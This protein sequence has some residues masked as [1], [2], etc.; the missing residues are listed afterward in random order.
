MLKITRAEL[1]ISIDEISEE[2]IM[3]INELKE[4]E[5][6]AEGMFRKV[7]F[8][9]SNATIPREKYIKVF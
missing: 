9:R 4:I 3:I 7:D 8:N 2:E 5:A 1:S 6:K